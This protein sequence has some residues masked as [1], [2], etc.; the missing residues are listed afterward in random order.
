ML[1]WY[2]LEAGRFRIHYH[3]GLELSAQRVARLANQIEDQLVAMIGSRQ[4]ET[5]E[6]LLTDYSDSANGFA[7]SVPYS[8]IRLYVTAPDDMSALGEYDDWLSMLVAHE[9][10]HIVHVSSVSGLPALL[11]AVLGKQAV[12][13]QLQPRWLIE[14]LAVY[15]ETKLSGGGRLRSPAFDMMLRADVIDDNFASLDQISN[16]PRR[17]P[18][19]IYYLYGSK[20]V[21]F[22]ADLYGPTVFAAM[23]QDT[24]DDV[25]PFAVSR[26]FYRT[27]GRTVE[28]LYDAFRLSTKRRVDEQLARVVARGLREGQPLTSHGRTVSSPRYV[29]DACR[30][31]HITRPAAG[32][33]GSPAKAPG[34]ALIYFRNDGHERNGYYEIAWN[35]DEPTKEPLELLVSRGSGENSTFGA[36][37]SLW[38]ESAAPSRRRYDF[39]DL[40]RQLPGTT[41]P[42]GMD[43]SRQR[44]T[45]GRRAMDPDIARDGRHI[46]YVTNRAGTTTL[47]IAAIRADGSLTDERAL[48]PSSTYEQVF[49]PRFSPDGNRVVYSVWTKGG[50]RDL[51][52]VDVTSGQLEQPWKDRAVDQQPIFSPDGKWLFFS[53][54]RSGIPNIYAYDWARSKL[55]QVTNVR[56]GAFMPELSP[57]GRRLFYVGYGSRGFDLYT[58]PVDE[59]QFLEPSDE[60]IL[61][62]DRVMLE[63]RGHYPVHPYSPLPTIRPRALKLDYRNDASG[64]RLVLSTFGSDIVGHHGLS[65][66]AVFEPE[67]RD[68]DLYCSY[69]YGRLPLGLD[70]TAYRVVDPNNSY[71]YGSFRDSIDEVRVGAVTNISIPF[72]REFD[73][74][75]VSIGYSVE[76]V[77]SVLP[78]GLAADPYATIPTE[79]RRGVSSSLRL[80]YSYTS[81]EST[82]YAVGRERGLSLKL[83][84]NEAHRGLGSELEGTL[85]SGRLQGYLL[86]PWRKHHVLALSGIMRVNTG[87]AFGGASLGG[88]QNSDLLRGVIDQ[89]GQSRETLRGYPSGRFRGNR[90][91]LGQA[92]Y[93]FPLLFADRGITTL[94]LFLRTVGGAFGMDVGGAFN[95]FDPH[96]FDESIH[97]GYASELWFD[98]VL[99][100]RLE[101]TLILGY[102]A[103]K[104]VGAYDGGTTYL[105]VGSGL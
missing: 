57:D 85:I 44:M 76:R 61:R 19:G 30:R 93:R 38:F 58:M 49:T 23:A 1:K 27:T 37:C 87:D 41:S 15:A 39:T 14:G 89:A 40:F 20:F 26:P 86:M 13:N 7:A 72:P 90:L 46:V 11:N 17:W 3:G 9:D 4:N 79:P 94:P 99:G 65:A 60:P 70:A 18:N 54:D 22:V 80:A 42:N 104:G 92:E 53:S 105:I 97:V 31:G 47:R 33:T 32:E 77:D 5:T 29:P 71:N 56:S 102:A 66:T 95:G 84:V 12:P 63:D 69:G 36:D 74:Q 59:R 78:T 73:D 64:Q 24:G 34:G 100:Y 8:S 81:V 52:V 62:D 6:I 16:E 75:K 48:V 68:P 91:I 96:A 45:V 43:S 101:M 103:G 55:W 83:S 67:G 28:E 35:T 51:R 25:M 88:Y 50:F 21:E 98:M 2:T 82:H 10:T